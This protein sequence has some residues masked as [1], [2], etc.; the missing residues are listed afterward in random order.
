VGYPGDVV[1]ST[2]LQLGTSAVAGHPSLSV[3][4]LDLTG[5]W[6][7]WDYNTAQVQQLLK[8]HPTEITLQVRTPCPAYL[9]SCSLHGSRSISFFTFAS[10]VNVV[11]DTAQS[12]L[13]LQLA[14][15]DP[16]IV[17]PIHT[18]TQCPLL[19]PHRSRLQ[20][21]R[22]TCYEL[23]HATCQWGSCLWTTG[24][25]PQRA[26]LVGRGTASTYCDSSASDSAR[27]DILQM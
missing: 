22:S 8:E 7:H 9:P 1:D 18:L 10:S 2:G 17:Q 15:A 4:E 12:L 19:L 3:A 26:T 5:V 27:C 13:C 25:S 14:A 6:V 20:A 23:Q 21:R 11:R 24:S 16:C